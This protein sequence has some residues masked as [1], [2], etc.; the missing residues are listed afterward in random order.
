MVLATSTWSLLGPRNRMPRCV[1]LERYLTTLNQDKKV[2]TKQDVILAANQAS[3]KP[4]SAAAATAVA[5]DESKDEKKAADKVC[6]NRGHHAWVCAGQDGQGSRAE[7][8]TQR[9][10]WR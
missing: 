9:R 3:K 4:K 5:M 1:F 7:K 8:G 6:V 10:Q 2:A